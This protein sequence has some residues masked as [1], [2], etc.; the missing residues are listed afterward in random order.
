[1][2][3]TKR[4]ANVQQALDERRP[5]GTTCLVNWVHYKEVRVK[6]TAV[7]HRGENA[8]AVEARVLKRLH[9][10]INP[11]PSELPS[12]GWPFRQPLRASHVYDIMLA[13]PGVNFVDNVELLVD[14]VP[15]GK[16]T[17]LAVDA[18][19]AHTWYAATGSR[20][21]RSM[22]NGDGWELVE[23]F[24]ENET[25]YCV[26]PNQFKAGEVALISNLICG[27]SDSQVV[28]GSR[29]YVSQDCGET[30]RK[31]AELLPQRF[32]DVAWVPRQSGKILM[33]AAD[34]TLYEL[35]LMPGAS[36]APVSVDASRP[37]M[38][39]YA[40][41]STVGVRGT[42]YVAAAAQQSNGVFLSTRGGQG[43]WDIIRLKGDDIRVLKV[44]KEENQTYL[45]AGITLM[46]NEVPKPGE[47]GVGGTVR[48]ELQGDTS[49]GNGTIMRKNW[50]GGSCHDLAFTTDYAFAAT[51]DKGVMW[52]DLRKGTTAQWN[53]PLLG[54]GLPLR[55]NKMNFQPMEEVAANPADNVVMGGSP[56]GIHRTRDNG[57]DFQSCSE[58]EFS[59]KVTLPD[60]WL[61]VSGEHEVDV[62]SEDASR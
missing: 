20:L 37:K 58:K 25:T 48:W 56:N 29:L 31:V 42:V 22:D 44:Q 45:W 26:R 41:T 3:L 9:Q 11:L 62:K 6:A 49:P 51:H 8:E 16:I 55:D 36:V 33:I 7:V 17:S 50:A 24:P 57:L 61:F 32:R 47:D 5:L 53:Q 27:P 46:G 23:Q 38:G 2:R 14:E 30:W 28:L 40:V 13:E 19:Q 52:L 54:S 1:M 15:D 35:A 34:E 4:L 12:A 21:F 59:D 18:F 60:T 10:S 39:F 43:N